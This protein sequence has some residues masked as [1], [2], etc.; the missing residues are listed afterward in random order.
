MPLAASFVQARYTRQ[1]IADIVGIPSDLLAYW[2]KEGLL[3]AAEGEGL[4]KGKHRLFGFEAIHIAA[5][6]KELG[7]Y[8]VQTSGLKQMAT[9]LWS[10][11][12]FCSLHPDVTES[13]RHSAAALHRAKARYP[14][15]SSLA[16]DAKAPASDYSCFEDW[17]EDRG[18]ISDKAREIA[19]WFDEMADLSFALYLDLFSEAI[20]H[21]LDTRWIFTHSGDDLIAVPEDLPLESI[22][23]ENLRS[24]ITIN[25]SLIIKPLWN[26]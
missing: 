3:V 16:A 6:L 8:G 18:P 13:V 26:P 10:V 14:S 1:Q 25:L 11:V 15:R 9:L 21:E 7:R 5:V 12:R 4:G 17:L 19:P 22:N 23:P 24:Y 20:F 2:S